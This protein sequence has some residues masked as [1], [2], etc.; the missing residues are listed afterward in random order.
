MPELK[1]SWTLSPGAFR[2]LLDW[3]DDG[4]DSGGE[5]YLEIRRRLTA[6]FDRK[7]CPC[8]DEL[9]D[10]TLN[11]IA[12][13]LEEKGA[14][15]DVSALHYC[16]I[17]AKFFFLENVRR[18]KP[19]QT[20]ATELLNSDS[21]THLEAGVSEIGTEDLRERMFGC[22]EKCLAELSANEREL[23]L[24]YYQ[25]EK[26]AKIERRSELT[27]RLGITMNALSIRACR[28]RNKLEACVKKC[29]GQT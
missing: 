23:I 25:G 7:N 6:Y 8:A 9:A 18:A 26:R 22:L 14:I 4:S 13:K 19:I 1:K 24:E 11:R 16:Y 12:R 29:S 5:R 21:A 2:R 17:L 27:T 20:G 15:T 3:L 10:E 28:I